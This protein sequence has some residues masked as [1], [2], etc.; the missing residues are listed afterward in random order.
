RLRAPPCFFSGHLCREFLC[1]GGLPRYASFCGPGAD[2]CN[3]YLRQRWV[4][5]FRRPQVDT[6]IKAVATASM[7][8]ISA[9]GRI[10]MTQEQLREELPKLNEQR[11]KDIESGSPEYLP[12]FPETPADSVPEE[13]DPVSA[14]FYS[15]YGLKRGHH[16][17]ARGGFT[18]TSQLAM[19]NFCSLDFVDQI[20]PRPILMI[21]G[22][23]AH[24]KFFSENVYKAAAEP[25]E[26]YAV[27]DAIHIDLYDRLDK[28]PFD[29]LESFFKEAFKK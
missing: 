19:L 7:Y 4:R 15:Y 14:E 1:R 11:W 6:R 24:S 27:P 29:K 13:L 3:R 2:R 22:E 8:D 17:N 18:T 12:Y 25:K 26:L 5:P 23:N 9:A 20:S 28:I 16:P 21:V 10:F